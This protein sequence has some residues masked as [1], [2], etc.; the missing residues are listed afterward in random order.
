MN[1]EGVII[2]LDGLGE[3][4]ANLKYDGFTE[5]WYD[6]ITMVIIKR[7]YGIYKMCNTILSSQ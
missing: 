7:I 5:Q 1:Y 3:V 2:E 4:R 6:V